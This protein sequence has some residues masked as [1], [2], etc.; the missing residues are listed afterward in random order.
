MKKLY[1]IILTL[2]TIISN[3]QNIFPEKFN[4]CSTEEMSLESDS[5]Y[6][7]TNTL[8]LIKLIK[9][10][11]SKEKKQNLKGVL[12]IQIVVNL[13]GSSCLISFKNDTN[14]KSSELNLK[15]IIDSNLKW[16]KP[17]EIVSPI[18]LFNFYEENV[19]YKRIGINSKKGNHLI[20]EKTFYN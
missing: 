19:S 18:I 3:S 4:N 8:D 1:L 13:D 14:L 12:S 7:E 11:L 17:K 5:V 9:S 10:N 20:E 15:N 16:E 6:T 2:F